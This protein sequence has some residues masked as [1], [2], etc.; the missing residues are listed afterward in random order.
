M[1]ITIPVISGFAML[2]CSKTGYSLNIYKDSIQ[3]E[4]DLN[5]CRRQEKNYF[6]RGD[7]ESI[8]L[9]SSSCDSVKAMVARL[10]QKVDNSSMQQSLTSLQADFDQYAIVFQQIV[11]ARN[12]HGVS[13][14]TIP[15]MHMGAEIARKCHESA[16]AI[17]ELAENQYL[18]TKSDASWMSIISIAIGLFISIIAAFYI[19]R[20]TVHEAPPIV[21]A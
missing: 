14:Q 4:R 15:I 16:A 11:S 18:R 21:E 3:L 6:M 1:V 8:R 7:I 9:Q 12:T 17:T 13:G 5:A 2:L 10:Q 20:N 19:V